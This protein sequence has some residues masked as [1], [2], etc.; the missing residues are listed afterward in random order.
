MMLSCGMILMAF[1]KSHI[2]YW[3]EN[4]LAEQVAGGDSSDDGKGRKWKIQETEGVEWSG[5]ETRMT[6][7]HTHMLLAGST[8]WVMRPFTLVGE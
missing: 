2:G 6:H 3:G 4:G 8:G 7:T 1:L 5:L